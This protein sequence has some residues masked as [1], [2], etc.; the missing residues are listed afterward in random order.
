MMALFQRLAVVGINRL[1]QGW[2]EGW[3]EQTARTEIEAVRP[4]E[5][6]IRRPNRD[7]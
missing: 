2:V 4:G 7:F 6:R 3:V 5:R 1:I